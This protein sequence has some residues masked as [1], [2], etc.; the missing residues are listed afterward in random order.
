RNVAEAQLGELHR[1]LGALGLAAPDAGTIYDVTSCPGAES[2]NLA[3]TSSRELASTLTARL[4]ASSALAETARDLSIKISGCP[5]SCGP[6]PIPSTGFRGGMRRI[7]GKIMP[8]YTPPPGGGIDA[9]GATFGRTIIKPPARRCG[10]AL[11][12]LLDAYAEKR[13]PGEKAL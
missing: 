11:V 9:N 5:N 1:G 10:D 3:V 7:G 13:A 4:E 12:R 6:H 2:C 8:E